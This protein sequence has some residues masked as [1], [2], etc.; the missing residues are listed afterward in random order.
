MI[1]YAIIINELKFG[2]INQPTNK[3]FNSEEQAQ[4]QVEQFAKDYITAMK[5]LCPQNQYDYAKKLNML[6]NTIYY[7]NEIFEN[8]KVAFYFDILPFEI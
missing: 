8:G 3:L 1:K 5:K 7:D 6:V 4:E 2:T